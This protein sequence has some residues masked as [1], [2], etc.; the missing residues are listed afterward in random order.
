MFF[1]EVKFGVLHLCALFRG[2]SEITTHFRCACSVELISVVFGA[3]D[4]KQH[5]EEKMLLY[6]SNHSFTYSSQ[7][8]VSTERKEEG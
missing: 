3:L 5:G 6:C 1:S 2:Q 7:R 4:V 8:S